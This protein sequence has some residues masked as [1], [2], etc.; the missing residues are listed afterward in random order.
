MK[1][2]DKGEWGAAVN[3]TPRTYLEAAARRRAEKQK[4]PEGVASPNQ[5]TAG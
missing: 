5:V 4:K 3:R 2:E 1:G